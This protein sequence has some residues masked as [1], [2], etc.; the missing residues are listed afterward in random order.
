[1]SHGMFWANIPNELKVLRQWCYTDPRDPDPKQVKAP[2]KSGGYLASN[3]KPSDWMSFEEAC[4]NA[5]RTGGHIGIIL[6]E[7]DP[8]TVIDL[9][10]CNEQTQLAKGEPRDPSLWTTQEN[11]D[12]FW[13]ISQAFNSYTEISAGGIG[14]HIMVNGAI[15]K[16]CRRDGVEVYS[17]ERFMICTGN[18]IINQPILPHQ[19]LLEMLVKEIRLAQELEIPKIDLIEYDEELT[20]EEIFNKAASAENA[21][22]FN[23]LCACTS[24]NLLQGTK[25]SWTQLGYKSQSEADLALMSIFTFYSKSNEQCRRLFR[26]SGLGRREKSSKD[27]RH[28]DN[29][30]RLIRS[31][32]AKSEEINLEQMARAAELAAQYALEQANNHQAGTLMHVTGQGEP[33]V[34]PAP[35]AAAVASLAHIPQ[36]DDGIAWPPGMAGQMAYFVYQSSPRP[37]KEVSIVAAIG[38]LAGVLGK[39]Y[40][41][42]QSGLNMYITLVARSGVGKEAMHSGIAKLLQAAAERQPPASKFIDFT[43]YVSGPA[44][45]K[46][47]I[48]NSCF[49]NVCNEWGRRLERLAKDNANDSAMHSLRTTMTELYQKSSNDS[50]VGGMGYSNKD[51]NISSVNGV[52]Y[53]FVGEATPGKFFGSLTPSMMEDG[54]LSR[55]WTVE[56]V[57]DRPDLNENPILTPSKSL[58]DA[59]GEMCTQSLNLLARGN[60]CMVN[61]TEGAAQMIKT[62]GIEC[63]T[64]I[65]G[66]E[67][68]GFRQMWNRAA[69]KVM[70]IASLLAAADNWINPVVTEEHVTWA[71]DAIR[72]DIQLFERRIVEGDVGGATDHNLGAKMRA[73]IGKYIRG[74]YPN[75]KTLSYSPEMMKNL[76]ITKRFLAAKCAGA[77]AFSQHRS[78]SQYAIDNTIKALID[79]GYLSIVDKTELVKN[80]AFHG[81]AYRVLDTL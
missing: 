29:C 45:T 65:R 43:S 55:F 4:Y 74:Q 3:V 66:S 16:G 59:L 40:G 9:D 70:R 71:L 57:G 26:M 61:R 67:D 46:A 72:R 2:R 48:G 81:V 44:L 80:H 21:E 12:R 11:L 14:L 41:F 15:G 17:R 75:T 13:A 53:S 24:N 28:L 49:L 36:A 73:V 7:S 25:G 1:M 10:V 23:R 42:S 69:L 76:I 33:T 20:D 77:A 52:A 47:V 35:A 63:D 8:Y 68:E 39:S 58:A 79:N 78:G 22:K 51:S 54:F 31:R 6:T 18:I 27:N 34:H 32:Q 5:E 60:Q 38:F 56:H 64:N 37:V 50:I 62:F 19:D 30:L